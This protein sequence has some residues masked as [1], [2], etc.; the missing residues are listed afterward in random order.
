MN[1][2]SNTQQN[3]TVQQPKYSDRFRLR[4]VKFAAL[5][6][7]TVLLGWGI[8]GLIGNRFD[9]GALWFLEYMGKPQVGDSRM[10]VVSFILVFGSIVYF[11]W[12]HR[13]VLLEEI[14]RLHDIANEKETFATRQRDKNRTLA[15][16]LAELQQQ[17]AEVKTQLS[18]EKQRSTAALHELAALRANYNSQ[19]D[20]VSRLTR[21]YAQLQSETE[22]LSIELEDRKAALQRAGQL[23]TLDFDLLKMLTTIIHSRAEDREIQMRSLLDKFLKQVVQVFD[24]ELCRASI[25]RPDS[26][27][28]Y[29]EPWGHFKMPEESLRNNR[30][31]IGD[32][33]QERR[34]AAGVCY[35]T[36][37]YKI[38][39]IIEDGP[40]YRSDDPDFVL[41]EGNMVEP[42]YRSVAIVPMRAPEG[43]CLG[44]LCLDSSDQTTFDGPGIANF[45]TSLAQRMASAAVVYN[46][47]VSADY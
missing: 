16:E 45:L 10:W 46:H 19:R 6:G 44:V 41:D 18:S 13:N 1:N 38:I 34:G 4:P 21:E 11:G 39:H 30:F 35:K 22:P 37:D 25:W 3:T 42:C 17:H 12:H 27:S 47:V 28:E 14:D 15:R 36:K 24:P 20:Q 7:T 33:N 32:G 31:Y 26:A 2:G 43:R 5:S 8:G 9:A 23:A 29:L 40:L